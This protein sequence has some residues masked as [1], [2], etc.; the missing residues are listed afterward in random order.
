MEAAAAFR[1][2][3]GLHLTCAVA[4]VPPV[5][6]SALNRLAGSCRGRARRGSARSNNIQHKGWVLAQVAKGM[7]GR[8]CAAN[9]MTHP[10]WALRLSTCTAPAAL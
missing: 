4:Y 8:G 7:G 10:H 5:T 3:R 1:C 9:Q 2:L 6:E